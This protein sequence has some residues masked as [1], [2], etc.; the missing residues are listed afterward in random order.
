MRTKPTRPEG[1]DRR[2]R[3]LIGCGLGGCLAPLLLLLVSASLGDTGG[4]L[5]WPL[6]A[7]LLGAVGSVIGSLVGGPPKE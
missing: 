7:L 5:F 1:E 2:R 4:P 6:L 3:G